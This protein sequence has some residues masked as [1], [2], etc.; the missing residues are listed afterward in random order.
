MIERTERPMIIGGFRVPVANVPY[1]Q[2]NAAATFLYTK[3]PEVPF[4]ATYYDT[5]K[6]RKFS[7]RSNATTGADVDAIARKYGTGGGHVH[8]AGLMM[9]LNWQGDWMESV[10]YIDQYSYKQR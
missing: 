2:R 7:L 4:A 3:Y 10:Q 1:A 8:A 5:P 6:G 9:P